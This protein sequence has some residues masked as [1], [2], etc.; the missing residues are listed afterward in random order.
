MRESDNITKEPR[1]LRKEIYD[2]M[3]RD[4]KLAVLSAVA[5]GKWQIVEGMKTI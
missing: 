5:A 4:H 3:D 2:H 1:I